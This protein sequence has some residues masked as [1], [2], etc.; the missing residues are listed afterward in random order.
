MSTICIKNLRPTGSDLLFDSESYLSELVEEE[1]DLI[2]GGTGVPT[3]THTM[4]TGTYCAAVSILNQTPNAYKVS[5]NVS[6]NLGKR[7]K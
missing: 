5:Y 6:Y 4:M 7:F 3:V 2:Q 1:L